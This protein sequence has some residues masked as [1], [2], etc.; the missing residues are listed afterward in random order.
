MPKKHRDKNLAR[1]TSQASQ[2]SRANSHPFDQLPLI[3]QL[4]LIT[5]HHRQKSGLTQQELA[6]LAGVGKTVIFDIEKGKPSIRLN[7]LLKV[8]GVLNIHLSFESPLME[9]FSKGFKDPNEKS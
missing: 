1:K 8:F 6:Q 2:E 7:T 5:R 3:E 4:P 9:K